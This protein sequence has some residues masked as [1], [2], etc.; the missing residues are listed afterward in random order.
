MSNTWT[1]SELKEEFSY[2]TEERLALMIGLDQPTAEQLCA[3]F[4]E[5]DA[6]CEELRKQ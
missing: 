5:A 4:E 1:E 3:A 6:A 2:R